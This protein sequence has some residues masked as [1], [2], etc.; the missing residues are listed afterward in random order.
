MSLC[1]AGITGHLSLA[2]VSGKLMPAAL[3]VMLGLAPGVAFGTDLETARAAYEREDYEAALR[4]LRPLAEQGDAEARVMLGEMYYSGKG[5][6]GNGV[7]KDYGEALKW[8][9][10]AAEQGHAAAQHRLGLILNYRDDMV[11][12][13]LRGESRWIRLMHVYRL[14]LNKWL[15]EG[16]KR[17]ITTYTGLGWMITKTSR[18]PSTLVLAWAG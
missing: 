5:V 8:V 1:C 3:L 14:G 18:L 2:R 16:L 6:P 11:P 13:E 15:S 10:P 12:S 7:P 9:K 4:E 17:Q